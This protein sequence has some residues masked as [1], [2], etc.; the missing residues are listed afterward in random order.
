M[1]ETPHL[2]RVIVR[3]TTASVLCDR[4]NCFP[5]GHERTDRASDG[6]EGR[7]MDDYDERDHEA[8][9]VEIFSAWEIV[10][11]ALLAMLALSVF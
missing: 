3:F 10:A 11:V 9:G 1:C 5:C 8:G 7:Q 2:P 6:V 4:G